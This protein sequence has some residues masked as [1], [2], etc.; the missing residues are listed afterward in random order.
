MKWTVGLKDKSRLLGSNMKL[1]V[2]FSDGE[3]EYIKGLA[4]KDR[5]SVSSFIRKLMLDRIS[6]KRADEKQG[7]GKP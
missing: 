3:G 7:G 6:M 1:Q 4:I 5:R 2:V